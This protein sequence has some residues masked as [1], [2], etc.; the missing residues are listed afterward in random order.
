MALEAVEGSFSL[1]EQSISLLSHQL[2]KQSLSLSFPLLTFLMTVDKDVCRQELWEC[3]CL[4][5][6]LKVYPFLCGHSKHK[7]LL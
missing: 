7:M 1:Y 2:R 3:H 4:L 6:V 5:G